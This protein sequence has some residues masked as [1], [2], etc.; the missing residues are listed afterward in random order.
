MGSATAANLTEWYHKISQ[1]LHVPGL[2][3]PFPH[4]ESQ[5]PFTGKC[6]GT[7]A[8]KIKYTL[9]AHHEIAV[10]G[11]EKP[12]FWAYSVMRMRG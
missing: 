10:F 5:S 1:K 7:W 8:V 9:V 3:A 6:M 4:V 2:L 12:S 11:C